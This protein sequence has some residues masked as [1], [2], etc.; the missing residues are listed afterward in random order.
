VQARV[1][2]QGR[3]GALLDGRDGSGIGGVFTGGQLHIAVAGDGEAFAHAQGHVA[4]IRGCGRGLAAGSQKHRL[5]ARI[6]AAMQLDRIGGSEDRGA[7]D[8]DMHAG[9]GAQG[10]GGADGIDVRG[11]TG[12]IA[13]GDIEA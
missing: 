4:E 11:F 12:A 8:A 10:S 9:I 3:L 13:G 2:A 7:A 1:G 6:V 5:I